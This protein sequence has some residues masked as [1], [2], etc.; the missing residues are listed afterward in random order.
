MNIA[1][2]KNYM[3]LKRGNKVSIVSYQSRNREEKY[4]GTI[5][6]TYKNVFTI[7]LKNGNIKSFTYVD[8]LIGSICVYI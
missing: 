4:E 1:K 7:R 3:Y 2:I 8:V 5:L 6:E